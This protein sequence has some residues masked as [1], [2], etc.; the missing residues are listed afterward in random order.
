MS[1]VVY[2]R[3]A[4][5]YAVGSA[6]ATVMGIRKHRTMIV[7]TIVLVFGFGFVCIW[8][9]GRATYMLEMRH[10]WSPTHDRM[11]Q[12]TRTMPEMILYTYISLSFQVAV[13][14]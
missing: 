3:G 7:R 13:L 10:Q 9:D 6:V 2:C 4:S 11:F 12:R 1:V 14:E 8:D 5:A